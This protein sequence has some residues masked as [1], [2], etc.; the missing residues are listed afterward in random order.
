MSLQPF[1]D[2]PECP[3]CLCT[4]IGTSYCE[5]PKYHWQKCATL[6]G[7]KEHLH[8]KCRRCSFAWV[9]ACAQANDV[10]ATVEV[11]RE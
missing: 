4:D 8:R 3:K 10:P 9:E 7:L 5:A 6:V 1:S 11:D 2:R